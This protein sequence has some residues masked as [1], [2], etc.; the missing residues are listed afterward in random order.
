MQSVEVIS[1][2]AFDEED[3]LPIEVIRAHTKTDDTPLVTDEQL[4][5]YRSAALEDAELY[6]GRIIRGLKTI[7]ETD[8]I[9]YEKL[10][11]R[12]P[13][14]RIKLAYLPFDPFITVH[15]GNARKKMDVKR[16]TR[17]L[18]IPIW[19]AFAHLSPFGCCAPCGGSVGDAAGFT[20]K[21]TYRTGYENKSDIPATILYGCL[22]WIMWA[23]SNPGDELLTVRNRL[24]TTET[25]LI[26]TNNG[27]WA[28]GAIE[29]WMNY[30]V[31]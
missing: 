23:V 13:T 2:K 11:R 9:G 28:S 22:K 18:D 24:G 14:A 10:E 15:L 8:V 12:R 25:G 20:M 30:R 21:M 16:Q 17:K 31:N 26:G 3:V 29:S 1:Y 6:T 19:D 4:K 5:I 7:S 27:A